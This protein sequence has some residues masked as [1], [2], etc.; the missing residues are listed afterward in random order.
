MT[1]QILQRY[2][3]KLCPAML[4]RRGVP[5]ISFLKAPSQ[6]SG[7][8]LVKWTGL[9]LT[10]FASISLFSHWPFERAPM[11]VEPPHKQVAAF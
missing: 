9:T 2:R 6:V 3:T 1:E 8:Q 4:A 10:C 7:P 5:C 11:K